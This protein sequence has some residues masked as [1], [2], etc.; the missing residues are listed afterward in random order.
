MIE[1]LGERSDGPLDERLG[2]FTRFVLPFAYELEP[3]E[4]QATLVYRQ[5]SADHLDGDAGYEKYHYHTIET[6]RALYRRAAWYQLE[7][8]DPSHTWCATVDVSRRDSSHNQAKYRVK[9]EA[10]LALFESDSRARLLRIGFLLLDLTFPDQRR[11]PTLDDLL[12]LNE[13]FR[14]WRLPWH[15]HENH[16]YA[17]LVDHFESQLPEKIPSRQQTYL[18]RWTR[19]LR[20][21]IERDGKLF[22][23]V[24]WRSLEEAEDAT[25]K[26][27]KESWGQG[28][29]VYTDN[30]AFV[31]TCAVLPGGV[32]A[33]RRRV[34]PSGQ[35]RPAHE[36]GHWVKLLNVD[37]PA[38]RPQR[39]GETNTF[40]RG[41]AKDRTYQRWTEGD[42]VYGFTTHS[43]AAVV[44]RNGLPLAR[45]FRD[46][47]F[48]QTLLLLYVRMCTFRFSTELSRI[49]GD[50][51]DRKVRRDD[52][53]RREFAKLR[54][55]FALLTNLYL[56]P[57]VS[58]QQQGIEL[59]SLARKHL[60][61]E[62]L[63][64]EVEAEV[65]KTHEYF[66]A[67]AEQTQASQT[68][69]LTWIG[70]LFLPLALLIGF[71]GM[72]I[73][74]AGTMLMIDTPPR[75]FWQVFLAGA[76]GLPLMIFLSTRLF[77]ALNSAWPRL[78]E[79]TRQ[80]FEAAIR[81]VQATS[82]SSLAKPGS[83]D[84]TFFLGG[85]DLEMDTIRELLFSM[86]D[87]RVHDQRLAWGA[88]MSDYKGLIERELRAGHT[89]VPIE[90]RDDIGLPTDQT[91][92][93]DHH[94]NRAGDHLATSLQQIFE[95]LGLPRSRWTRWYELVAAN[96]RGGIPGLRRA[97]ATVEEVREVRDRER[98]ILGIT[99]KE[100]DA[101]R[102][103]IASAEWRRD[104]SLAVVRLPHAHA[105]AAAD[106]LEPEY[107]GRGATNLLVISPGEVNFFGEGRAVRALAERFP[108][109]W[110]G[111]DLP[112]L[113]F[114]GGHFSPSE[115]ET[116]VEEFL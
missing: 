1:L 104:G 16:G 15:G 33:I 83:Q 101:A 60:D 110:W 45:H 81:R 30:R 115:V 75:S 94:G 70:T 96:D 23:L 61:V 44:P 2:S 11:A 36:L 58:N 102:A 52:E 3:F 65:L 51:L 76:L 8:G 25:R 55:E 32:A 114:W 98:A 99:R 21:P 88:S 40:E 41:W 39:T 86:P 5:R 105:A 97:G 14:F 6:A 113:G 47:Y 13:K 37:S 35:N 106:F 10:R 93:I 48:A 31:W 109:G 7:H 19:F 74:S 38:E 29:C 71:F 111:G 56:F 80:G 34:S 87:A 62:E 77:R 72:D 112:A 9:T 27:L 20:L 84:L 69:T 4:Q 59:Y 73:V 78:R 17:D 12:H 92:P 22:S 28:W 43:G 66:Q 53:W 50:A 91:I 54:R 24:S 103:A 79:A 63:F 26:P 108:E 46:L 85:Q 82:P 18:G 116:A 57:L 49:S 90:L 42:A 107:G 95:L 89:L 100:E 64:R 67:E 68:A